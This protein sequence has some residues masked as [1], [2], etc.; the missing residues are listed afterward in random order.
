MSSNNEKIITNCGSVEKRYGDKPEYLRYSAAHST[1]IINNTNISELSKNAYKRVPKK[2]YFDFHEDGEKIIWNASHDGYHNNYGK[3]VKRRMTIYKNEECILGEDTILPSKFNKKRL[4]YNIR[5]HLTPICSGLLTNNK[6]SI[7]I[8]TSRGQ[9]WI[10]TSENSISLEDS[11][12]IAN[13]RKIE[14]TKQIVISNYSDS[15]KRREKW[16][17]KKVN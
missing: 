1:L 14:Q 10:F 9:S 16:S 7:L 4:I 8:K 3:I 13:G 6:K 2:I 17:I 11:I 12:Y 15:S 5:F